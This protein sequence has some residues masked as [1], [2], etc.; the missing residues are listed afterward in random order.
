[1][2]TEINLFI[3]GGGDSKSTKA[4][5]R[6]GFGEFLIELHEIA[7][8]KR[9]RW[10]IVACG[11]REAA[12]DDF[13]TALKASPAVFNVLLVDSEASLVTAK[14]NKN[15]HWAHLKLRD[16]WDCPPSVNDAHCFLME[17]SME[18]WLI[19]DKKNL[20]IFYGQ[21]FNVNSLP[22]TKDIEAI[23]KVALMNALEAATT[24]T[25]TKGAYHKTKHGFD[26]LAKADPKVVRKAA[27]HCKRLFE[28]LLEEMGAKLIDE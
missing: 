18:T 13:C 2:V 1:L 8:N 6:E 9:I 25:K 17:Q 12:F 3:E 23:D 19:A 14:G 7:R 24:K 5:L 21:G 16:K 4:K 27:S 10:K 20:E 15:P 11:G 22:K 28:N 26:I